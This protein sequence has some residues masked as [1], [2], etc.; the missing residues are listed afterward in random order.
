MLFSISQY[1]QH[2][3][4]N[5]LNATHFTFH[6]NYVQHILQMQT[7]NHL[8]YIHFVIKKCTGC[9]MQHLHYGKVMLKSQSLP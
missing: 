1:I 9:L 5:K 7:V 4:W 8:I 3:F 2:I 6:N